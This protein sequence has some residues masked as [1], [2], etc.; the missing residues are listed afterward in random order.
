MI[1]SLTMPQFGESITQGRIVNWLKKEGDLVKEAEP[2]VEMETEKSVFSYE[3]P[4]TGKLVKILEASD[5][6]VQVG[7]EIA[8]FE[9]SEADGKK[10]L[11]IRLTPAKPDARLE[12]GGES[13]FSTPIPPIGSKTIPVSAIRSRIADNMILS[14]KSIPHAGTG[15]DVDLSIIDQ[16]RGKQTYLAF[17][18][19]AVIRSLQEHPLLYSLWKEAEGRRWIEQDTSINLG[20]AVSSDQGLLVPVIHRAE[21]LSFDQLTQETARLITEGKKGTL[22]PQE[23]S[24]GNFTANNTGSLG[25]TRSLQ[26]IPPQQSA[27]LAINRVVKRPWVDGDKVVIKPILSLDLAF[28]HRLIDGDQAIGFLVAVRDKLENFDFSA[29][30]SK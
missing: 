18:I 1:I 28:D 25:A 30:K 24:G 11:A 3:S 27:I 9:V 14:Q 16:K 12:L 17:V 6:E 2:L 22:K 8:Q 21:T 15:L 10:Y 26:I 4:F 29:L 23:L 7:S 5:R 19:W 20:L 13:R